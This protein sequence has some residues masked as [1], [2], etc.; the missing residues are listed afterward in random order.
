MNCTT[1]NHTTFEKYT[2]FQGHL[3]VA[4]QFIACLCNFE[5]TFP[6]EGN[7]N[8]SIPAKS[9]VCPTSNFGNT[10]PFE[11]NRNS[12]TSSLPHSL[13]SSLETLSRPPSTSYRKTRETLAWQSR[14]SLRDSLD[15]PHRCALEGFAQD[16]STVSNVSSAFSARVMRWD[17]RKS[18]GDNRR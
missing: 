10:F 16:V 2:Y 9:R 17:V 5:Y 4:R 12:C 1:T 8:S 7:R 14:S 3:L 18:A 15:S 13:K 11:G 6:F